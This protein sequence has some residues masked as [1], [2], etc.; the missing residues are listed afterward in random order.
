MVV[1]PL[2]DETVPLR[3]RG[4][5]ARNGPRSSELG[6]GVPCPKVFIPLYIMC[7]R[8]NKEVSCWESGQLQYGCV[9]F[10]GSP[11][12]AGF[13]GKPNGEPPFCGYHQEDKSI[14]LAARSREQMDRKGKYDMRSFAWKVRLKIAMLHLLIL[15][16]DLGLG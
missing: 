10:E 3:A 6:L 16:R 9:F 12:W 1:Q 11:V 4:N 7:N 2:A 8:D 5:I 15:C 14:W 13:K